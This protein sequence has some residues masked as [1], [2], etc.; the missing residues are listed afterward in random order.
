M[1]GPS[2]T[3]TEFGAASVGVAA[4]TGSSPAKAMTAKRMTFS[5]RIIPHHYTIAEPN[6]QSRY[7]TASRAQTL[8]SALRLVIGA[9]GIHLRTLRYFGHTCI[10]PM[11]AGRGGD[12]WVSAQYNDAGAI[13]GQR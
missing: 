6:F 9:R 8:C 10:P 13:R 2:S 12:A 5:T 11:P 7:T 3:A 1:D 4:S